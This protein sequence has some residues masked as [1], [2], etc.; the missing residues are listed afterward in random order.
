M[1]SFIKKNLESCG[2]KEG[3]GEICEMEVGPY[4][5]KM[6]KRRR[7]WDVVY[8]DPPYDS[9]YDEAMKYFSRGATVTPG[10]VLVIEHHSEMFF[11][12]KIG[13]M[14]RFRVVVQG[15]T[16]LSFYERKS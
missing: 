11:P 3:H 12:E 8:F 7:F 4:L 14:K 5:K 13:V 10:G 15:E 6:W 2:I 1:C 9:N 16:T